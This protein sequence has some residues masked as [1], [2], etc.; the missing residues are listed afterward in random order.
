LADREISA[1]IATGR[2]K[3]PDKAK[4]TLTGL[5]TRAMRDKLRRAGRRS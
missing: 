3:H 5:L 4:R 1:Y 2:A